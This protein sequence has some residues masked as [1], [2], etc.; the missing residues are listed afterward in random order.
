MLEFSIKVCTFYMIHIKTD[1]NHLGSEDKPL[2][3][4][5]GMTIDVDIVTGK[6]TVMEYILKPILKSKQYVFTER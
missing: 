5:N 2:E 1:K 3:I 4:I 6:K